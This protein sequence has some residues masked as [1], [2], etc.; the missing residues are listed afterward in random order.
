MA[1]A[2]DSKS[3]GSNTVWVQLPPPASLKKRVVVGGAIL[4]LLAAG[5]GGVAWNAWLK[6]R[7]IPKR[8][9]VV[10]AGAIYRSARLPPALLKK[11][12]GQ[13]RIRRIVDLT[14]ADPT[15]AGQQ[16]E[17]TVAAEL[18]V[19][20]LNYPLYG[21]GVGEIGSYAQAVAV[22]VA[23]KQAGRPVLVHC[24][25]G[26]QRTGGVVAAYRMLIEKRPPAEA[27]AELIRYGW[28]PKKNRILPDFLNEHMRELAE[29]LLEMRLIDAFPDPLPV[30]E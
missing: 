19:E 18:G 2:L 6:D 3:S 22:M 14:L 12:V 17:K 1:D 30:L 27:Y 16:T 25:A 15:D 29:R 13:Y 9:G 26:T 21:S 4:L 11:M 8:W 20:Y 10:E 23:A 24:A 28:N 7:L 5:L